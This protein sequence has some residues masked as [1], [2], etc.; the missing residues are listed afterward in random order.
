MHVGLHVYK[1]QHQ[2]EMYIA[3][4]HSKGDMQKAGPKY[5]SVK[6]NG[7]VMKCIKIKHCNLSKVIIPVKNFLHTTEQ[8]SKL[9]LRLKL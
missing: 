7:Q 4:P 5:Q 1:Q 9:Q 8:L 6:E 3:S 2:K